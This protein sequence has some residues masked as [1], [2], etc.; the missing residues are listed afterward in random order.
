M[1]TAIL[2]VCVNAVLQHTSSTSRFT[3]GL[4]KKYAVKHVHTACAYE[5]LYERC[6]RVNA[7]RDRP[8][9]IAHT[10]YDLND[11]E[12]PLSHKKI[13][14]KLVLLSE[15]K[16]IALIKDILAVH[17]YRTMEALHDILF[18][19]TWSNINWLV[20]QSDYNVRAYG[21]LHETL[22]ENCH[23]WQLN[24]IRNYLCGEIEKETREPCHVYMQNKDTR[25]AKGKVESIDAFLYLL[26]RVAS[27]KADF[28]L[29]MTGILEVALAN[30][31]D[32]YLADHFVRNFMRRAWSL[33]DGHKLHV[34]YCT[35]LLFCTAAIMRNEAAL[36]IARWDEF[37]SKSMYSIMKYIRYWHEVNISVHFAINV[38]YPASYCGSYI[39]Q[40]GDEEYAVLFDFFFSSVQ[41]EKKH[42][43]MEELLGNDDLMGRLPGTFYYRVFDDICRQE[44][45]QHPKH[46]EIVLSLLTRLPED[47]F[48]AVRELAVQNNNNNVLELSR[49]RSIMA[50]LQQHELQG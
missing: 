39:V 37:S 31:G 47:K 32:A 35:Y 20:R 43:R 38:V 16:P 36:S 23:T 10:K 24:R 27:R 25:A 17:P 26:R 15:K 3:V 49:H 4:T 14:I 41:V 7:G 29:E 30:A 34:D 13:F 33:E 8:M 19:A 1:R 11:V 21:A 48:A 22:R 9:K 18:K 50:L 12:R 45:E 28:Y 5:A 42:P 2:L 44:V 6:L 40:G 46:I